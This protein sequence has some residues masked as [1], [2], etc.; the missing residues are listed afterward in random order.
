MH[1]RAEGEGIPKVDVTVDFAQQEWYKKL[2]HKATSISQLDERALVVA[3]MSMLWVPKNPRGVPA[4][5]YQGK[6]GYSLLNVFDPR[7][8]GDMIEAIQPEG[9]PT[10]LDQIRNRFLHPTSE[11]FAAYTNTILGEDGED[12]FDDTLDPTREEVIVLSSEGSDKSH[13]RLTPH[14]PRAGPAQGAVNEPVN[15]P[16]G[17][18][19]PVETAEQLETRKKKKLDKTEKKE[20]RV[21]EN[22]AEVPHKRPS[23]PPFLDYVVVSDTL[24]GLDVGVLDDKKKELDEQAAAALAAKRAKLQKENPPVPS[25]SEIDMGVFSAKRGNLL[26]EI[27]IASG[28]RGA[29]SGKAPRKIDISKITPPAFPPSRTF[30]L[31]T[32]PPPPEM[33]RV[34]RE[35]KM[36]WRLSMLVKVVLVMRVVL[37]IVREWKLMG[38]DT[39]EFENAK[40]AFAEEREKFNAEKKGLLWRVSD[41]EQ[42]L[43]KEKQVNVDKQKNSESACE[44]TNKELQARREAIVRLSGE[45]TKIS[46][47]AEE[48]RAAHQKRERERERERVC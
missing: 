46:D 20:K 39:L 1:Y 11:S 15:E 36:M 28:S 3:G 25:E 23:I 40:K 16:I 48:E 44:R 32:P 2:T 26:E 45:K 27:Y 31:S 13:E 43:A 17:D 4:Y 18:D 30:D 42:K 33:T 10:W 47:E 35:N 38:E 24:S 8:G 34:K 5:G 6:V 9:R 22:V 21:E 19:P 41:V 14:S 37:E 29:K 7:A 12:D